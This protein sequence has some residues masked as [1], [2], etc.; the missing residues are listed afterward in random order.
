MYDF[1]NNI[2]VSNTLEYYISKCRL[3]Q[4]SYIEYKD[5]KD[6]EIVLITQFFLT[7]NQRRQKELNVC[8]THN[9]LNKNIDEI[10][11]L[12]ETFIDIRKYLTENIEFKYLEKV[13]QIIINDRLTLYR[14]IEYC[15]DNK[16]IYMISNSDIFFDDTL[17]MLKDINLEETILAL[18]RYDLIK[19]YVRKGQNEAKIFT[20]EG[21]LGN[22]VID[23]HDVWILTNNIKNDI[24]LDVPLGT[25][26]I[27]NIANYIFMDNGY[28]VVNPVFDIH[29]I[30]YHLDNYRND[31][32]NGMRNN[33]GKQVNK[34]YS[35]LNCD[36]KYIQQ[37]RLNIVYTIKSVCTLC[38]NMSY[39]NDLV[40]LL[41]SIR[42]YES[43]IDIYILCDTYVF[44]KVKK[45]FSDLNI[46]VR[47]GL[48]RYSD[49]NR[50][51]ME[52]KDNNMFKDLCF[53]KINCIEFALESS[54]NTLY[55]DA[56]IILMNRLELN[57]PTKYD[58]ALCPHNIFKRNTDLYGYYNAGMMFIA[59]KNICDTWRSCRETSRFLDQSSLEDI[60]MKYNILEL[61]DDYNYGWWRLFQ[62]DDVVERLN[63]FMVC[64]N[65][66][67]LLYDYIPLKCIHTHLYELNDIQTQQFNDII[68]KLIENNPNYKWLINSIE[69][70]N[71]KML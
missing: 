60:A 41:N 27:D 24:R 2:N 45:D 12:T 66:N 39:Y 33:S 28:K 62:C 20:H 25:C 50:V 23:S 65:T 1:D 21:Q 8:L 32:I 31:T 37:Q 46:Y 16:K 34:D 30:H 4:D 54:D 22:P 6:N 44:N 10:L 47:N 5:N 69:I 55:L 3:R 29:A 17:K 68:L 38:T 67:R 57:V 64:N 71:I 9:I 36:V 11:L 40:F 52:N 70:Y 49:M 13:R 15:K 42:Q 53:E 58:G 43:E 56:D 14:G 35:N 51:Q 59:N 18:S 26:G 7:D 63:K 48:D 61:G 19:E